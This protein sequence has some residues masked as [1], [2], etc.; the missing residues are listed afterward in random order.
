M[1]LILFYFFFLLGGEKYIVRSGAVVNCILDMRR[2]KHSLHFV[3]DG[4]LLPHA[5]VN[6]P[7]REKMHIGVFCNILFI[8]L[9]IYLFIFVF[10]YLSI[11]VYLYFIIYISMFI[12]L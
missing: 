7:N 10:I 11:F 2:D 1:F 6:I 12:Y 5:F 8:Y 4:E 3:V 9:I